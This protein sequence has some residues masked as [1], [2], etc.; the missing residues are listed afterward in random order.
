MG[1]QLG[2]RVDVQVALDREEG[3]I[4]PGDGDLDGQRVL[5]NGH[6]YLQRVLTASAGHPCPRQGNPHRAP[7]PT[8]ESIPHARPPRN[9]YGSGVP[10]VA[11]TTSAVM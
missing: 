10:P 7:A 5:G 2:R 3:D 9:P 11:L 4:L 8:P 1:L 6:E